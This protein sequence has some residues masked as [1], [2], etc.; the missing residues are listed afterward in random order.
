M[1]DDD[2]VILDRPWLESIGFDEDPQDQYFV[3][4]KLTVNSSYP[5][6]LVIEP[7]FTQETNGGEVMIQTWDH[8]EEQ[9]GEDTLAIVSTV[10]CL[11]TRGQLRRLLE[12]LGQT[13]EKV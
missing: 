6:Y 1:C 5:A 12:V 7:D 2:N 13:V 10:G 3:R 9:F 4:L 11:R 8:D